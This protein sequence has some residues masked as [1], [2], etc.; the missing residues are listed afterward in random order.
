MDKVADRFV[1]TYREVSGD[2]LASLEHWESVALCRPLPDIGVWVPAWNAMGRTISV[3][4][5]RARY[6]TV[7]ED[8]LT[9]TA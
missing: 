9:R 3:D 1:S 5:A 8:F 7:L 2:P 4:Q 6:D